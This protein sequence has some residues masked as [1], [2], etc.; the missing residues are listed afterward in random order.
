MAL[1]YIVL[2]A[3]HLCVPVRRQVRKVA[4]RR[5]DTVCVSGKTGEG[6]D[7]LMDLISAKLAQ[8][9]VE[10]RQAFGLHAAPWLVRG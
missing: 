8:R 1:T 6:L 7:T 3:R 2:C 9:M 5:R 10:V 4:A